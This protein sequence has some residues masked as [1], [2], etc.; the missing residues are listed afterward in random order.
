MRRD[1]QQPC[2][3]DTTPELPGVPR[4]TP[5]YPGVPCGTRGVPFGA[6]QT[7]KGADQRLVRAPGVLTLG[8]GACRCYAWSLGECACPQQVL[9]VLTQYET[10]G[11]CGR[12]PRAPK[13]TAALCGEVRAL[14]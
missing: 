14:A 9:G 8:H 10:R 12:A 13:T 6:E 3:T 2:M 1:T 4:S 5:E 11:R 7:A